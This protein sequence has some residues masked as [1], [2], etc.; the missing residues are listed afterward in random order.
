[1]RIEGAMNKKQNLSPKDLN[2][3]KLDEELVCVAM[4]CALPELC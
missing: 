1:M 2:L 4:I 3:E